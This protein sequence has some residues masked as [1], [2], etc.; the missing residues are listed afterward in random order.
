L[1][2]PR[3]NVQNYGLRFP[4]RNVNAI[5]SRQRPDR[6]LNAAGD[7][8][9]CSEIDLRHLVGRYGACV[10]DGDGHIETPIGN[11]IYLQAGVGKVGVAEAITERI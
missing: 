4:G 2:L 5:K 1:K 8:P 10:F 6:E 9:G 11:P 7:L 3:G